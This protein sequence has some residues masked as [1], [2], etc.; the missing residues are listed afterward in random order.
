MPLIVGAGT[1]GVITTVVSAA[2]GWKVDAYAPRGTDISSVPTPSHVV[3]WALIATELAPGGA[4]VEPVF[5]A[6][7]RTWTPD[8]FRAAYGAAIELKIAPL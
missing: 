4:V 7:G 2:P 8:Q 1:P 5:V 6:G 3:A